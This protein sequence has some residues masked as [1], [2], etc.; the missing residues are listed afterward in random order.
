[1]KEL[2]FC[3]VN[4]EDK[5]D[6]NGGAGNDEKKDAPWAREFGDKF[7]PD[8]AWETIQNSRKSERQMRNK[9]ESLE[10]RISER[11]DA[12]KS[13]IDKVK[14]QLEKLMEENN[15]YKQRERERTL[16]SVVA[17]AARKE[18]AIYPDDVYA[19][20]ASQLEVDDDG[21]PR[22]AD[23]IIRNLKSNR[24]MLFEDRNVDQNV[25]NRQRSN[26]Q[27]SNNMNDLIRRAAGKT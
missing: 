24:P 23:S 7:E 27:S 12:D 25:Q 4:D 21:K 17:E 22:N 19:L 3:F 8:K 9:L 1:M 16:S 5:G 26:N 14:S 15:T 20:V 10:K 11:D 2:G 13:E 6:D 18:G